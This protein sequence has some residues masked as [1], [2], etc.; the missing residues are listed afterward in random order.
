ARME[1]RNYRIVID[2]VNI[3]N[4]DPEVFLRFDCQVEQINNRSYYDSTR[5]FKYDVND[6]WVHADLA[7]WKLNNQKLKIFDVKFDVC[8]F[9]NN[10]QKNRLLNIFVKNIKA[11]S[12][13]DLKCPFPANVSHTVEKMFF[14]EKDFPTNLPLG[15]F[16]NI[17]EFLMNQKMSARLVIKGRITPN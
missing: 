10:I 7:F 5:I 16:R 2:D 6:F 15:K 3:S 12:N 14:D 8:N 11:H 1:E 4:V 13:T 17:I 9:L